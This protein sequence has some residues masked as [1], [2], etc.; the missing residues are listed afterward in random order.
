MAEGRWG[1]SCICEKNWGGKSSGFFRWRHVATAAHMLVMRIDLFVAC[2]HEGVSVRQ[3]F[4][5]DRAARMTYCAFVL[6]VPPPNIVTRV[7]DF[8]YTAE[9]YSLVFAPNMASIRRPASGRPSATLRTL[10][11]WRF[12]LRAFT[13]AG[14]VAKNDRMCYVQSI[15]TPATYVSR[16][17]NIDGDRVSAPTFSFSRNWPRHYAK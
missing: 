12:P 10:I 2:T 4:P 16:P 13:A 15:P 8:E 1:R 17:S 14:D 7:L 11:C 3:P 5:V 6:R 9:V